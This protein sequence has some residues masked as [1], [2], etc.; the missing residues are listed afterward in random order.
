MIAEPTLTRSRATT[1]RGYGC[2][3]TR[4]ASVI[5]ASSSTARTTGDAAN[6]L[7]AATSVNGANRRPM[8]RRCSSTVVPS[9]RRRAFSASAYATGIDVSRCRIIVMSMKS[10]KRGPRSSSWPPT[11]SPK[12]GRSSRSAKYRAVEVASA[13]TTSTQRASPA[14]IASACSVTSDC[15]DCPPTTSRSARSGVMP[16]RRATDR[17]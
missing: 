8:A 17:G 9:L 7:A 14:A 2:A 5:V 15:G 4:L 1:S 10:S 6:G 12:S 11:S 16:T 13:P 3:I